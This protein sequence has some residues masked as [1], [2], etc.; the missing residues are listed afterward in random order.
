M[1]VQREQISVK[2]TVTTPLG[3]IRVAAMTASSLTLLE[4]PALVRFLLDWALACYI[5][6]KVNKLHYSLTCACRHQRM[7][8][9]YSQL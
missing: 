5:C 2:Y 4:E 6:H 8:N 9:W 3:R 7:Q 1:S